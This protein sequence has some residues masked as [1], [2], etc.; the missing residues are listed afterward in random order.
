QDFAYHA[1]NVIDIALTAAT[2]A[3][4]D[5][6]R[7]RHDD[8]NH[9]GFAMMNAHARPQMIRNSFGKAVH[10]LG[11]RTAAEQRFEVLRFG[12]LVVYLIL[13]DHDRIHS[14]QMRPECLPSFPTFT[15]QAPYM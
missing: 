7:F 14:S 5:P 2:H 4:T 13:D 15:L 3:D 10:G 11:H 1:L 9:R 6:P 8:R 12:K